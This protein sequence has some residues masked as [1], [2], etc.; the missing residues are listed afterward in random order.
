M[1]FKPIAVVL[2]LGMFIAFMLI[3]IEVQLYTIAGLLR[4]LRNRFIPPDV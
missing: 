2:G 4:N 3:L 1:D